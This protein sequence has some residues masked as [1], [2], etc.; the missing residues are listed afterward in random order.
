MKA[1]VGPYIPDGASEGPSGM[2][3]ARC[4]VG[5]S[6]FGGYANPPFGATLGSAINA[7]TDGGVEPQYPVP[8]A[9]PLRRTAK[10]RC[11]PVARIILSKMVTLSYTALSTVQ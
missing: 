9:T 6:F 10:L 8:R 11:P 1:R 4:C 2:S 5:R 7:H 3:F